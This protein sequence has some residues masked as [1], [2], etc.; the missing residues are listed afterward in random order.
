MSLDCLEFWQ[1]SV[2]VKD[3]AAVDA[4]SDVMS[5]FR[6]CFPEKGRRTGGIARIYERG[7]LRCRPYDQGNARSLKQ[8]D[9][10]EYRSHAFDF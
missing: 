3:K 4:R 5:C 10:D 1:I 2:V 9:G 7:L 8:W 6:W